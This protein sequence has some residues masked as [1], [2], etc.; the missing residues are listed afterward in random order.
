ML[1][2][3]YNYIEKKRNRSL[4]DERKMH[5]QLERIEATQLARIQNKEATKSSKEKN[6]EDKSTMGFTQRQIWSLESQA[7]RQDKQKIK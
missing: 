5:E 7:L 3:K 2:T 4:Q 1:S 6:Q